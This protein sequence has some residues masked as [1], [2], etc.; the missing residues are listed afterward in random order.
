MFQNF[1]WRPF[2]PVDCFKVDESELK[3][4]GPVTPAIYSTIVIVYG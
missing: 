4:Y 2:F 3:C 1:E